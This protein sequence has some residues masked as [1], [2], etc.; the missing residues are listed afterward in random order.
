MDW[1]TIGS[2][3]DAVGGVAGTAA[4]FAAAIAILTTKRDQ[5]RRDASGLHGEMYFQAQELPL[6]VDLP[7]EPGAWSDSEMVCKVRNSSGHPYYSVVASV[8]LRSRQQRYAARADV[9]G[10]ATSL[11]ASLGL[12][13]GCDLAAMNDDVQVVLTFVDSQGRGWRRDETGILKRLPRW[14]MWRR[15]RQGASVYPGKAATLHGLREKETVEESSA[16]GRWQIVSSELVDAEGCITQLVI[17]GPGED[18]VQADKAARPPVSVERQELVSDLE[19]QGWPQ[20]PKPR[21]GSRWLKGKPR[22]RKQ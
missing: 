22:G 6:D 20:M 17:L 13:I 19:L 9:I 1:N 21:W 5:T 3:G 10:P 4:A 18:Q 15:T 12:V 2:A 14:K 7:D 11:C 8:F 16:P